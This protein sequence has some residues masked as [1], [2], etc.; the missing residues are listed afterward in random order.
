MSDLARN[1]RVA[2]DAPDMGAYELPCE[3][4]STEPHCQHA[5]SCEEMNGC[6][7][8]DPSHRGVHQRSLHRE[9]AERAR[10]GALHL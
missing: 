6:V 4:D 2:G 7:S 9:R 10:A 3:P 5:P 1:P 8:D